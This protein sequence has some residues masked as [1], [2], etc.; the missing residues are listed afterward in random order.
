[1]NKYSEKRDF[2][3]Q[4]RLSAREPSVAATQVPGDS[5]LR[6]GSLS[7]APYGMCAVATTAMPVPVSVFPRAGSMTMMVLVTLME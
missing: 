1:M 6:K 2:V 4:N 3:K 7:A 5:S